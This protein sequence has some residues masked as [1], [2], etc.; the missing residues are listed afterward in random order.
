MDAKIKQIL[1]NIM[2]ILI[3]IFFLLLLVFIFVDFNH[4]L[5]FGMFLLMLFASS[6]IGFICVIIIELNKLYK[7]KTRNSEYIETLKIV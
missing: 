6:S 3:W 7:H 1:Y 5:T 2:M 4:K